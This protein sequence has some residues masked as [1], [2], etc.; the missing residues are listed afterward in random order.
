M[1][2]NPTDH[3]RPLIFA[4]KVLFRLMPVPGLFSYAIGLKTNI[5]SGVVALM[6]QINSKLNPYQVRSILIKSAEK[7]TSGQQSSGLVR[8]D[9]AVKKVAN[10]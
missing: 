5:V 9:I 3:V 2:K 7:L 4:Y 6:L 8:A 10:I 1:F